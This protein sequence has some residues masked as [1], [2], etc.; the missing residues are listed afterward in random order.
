MG[1]RMPSC[2]AHSHPKSTQGGEDHLVLDVAD[3]EDQVAVLGAGP[4]QNGGVLLVGQELLVG[5]RDLAV[6]HS[7][8]GQALGLVG[9]DELAQLVDLLPGEVLGVAVHV[10]ETDG[11]AGLDRLGRTRRSRS[12]SPGRRCPAAQSRSACR[13]YRNRSGP[14]PPARASAGRGSARPRPALP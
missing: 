1:S 2:L 4:L 3:D 10:N 6:Q 14:W 13:A 12:P 5:R 8:P 11:A 9:L 7:G